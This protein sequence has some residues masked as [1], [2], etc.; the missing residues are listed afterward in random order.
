M[1]R[2]CKCLLPNGL[3]R[4]KSPQLGA[5]AAR[6]EPPGKNE[7]TVLMYWDGLQKFKSLIIRRSLQTQHQFPF[8]FQNRYGPCKRPIL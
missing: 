1:A 7:K 4:R 2:P 5:L 8:H 3:L 6:R